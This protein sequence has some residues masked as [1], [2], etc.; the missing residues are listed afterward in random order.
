M[1]PLGPPQRSHFNASTSKF[2]RKPKLTLQQIN[3][4]RK[5]IDEGE[6]REDPASLLNVNR[7]TLYRALAG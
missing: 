6:R 4:A 7:T 5:L 2:D 3:H 1:N